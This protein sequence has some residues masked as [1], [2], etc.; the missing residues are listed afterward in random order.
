MKKNAK[1]SRQYRRVN[2]TY[3]TVRPLSLCDGALLATRRA[4]DDCE[5]RGWI[6]EELDVP[7]SSFCR[8]LNNNSFSVE[9][10]EQWGKLWKMRKD[11]LVK[12]LAFDPNSPSMLITRI[13]QPDEPCTQLLYELLQA[14]DVVNRNLNQSIVDQQT[15]VKLWLGYPSEVAIMSPRLHHTT[16]VLIDARLDEAQCE[17]R[18]DEAIL[19]CVASWGGYQLKAELEY[20]MSN[21]ATVYR[22][23]AYGAYSTASIPVEFT[24]LSII[25]A[26]FDGL[27]IDRLDKIKRIYT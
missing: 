26:P 27:D 13:A 17:C 1:L 16:G 3:Q 8:M 6:S 21:V 14:C 22:G 2:S 11:K 23:V 18:M 24:K 15:A 5:I 25:K 7:F 12:M 20:W 19:Y 4:L 9:L 10:L